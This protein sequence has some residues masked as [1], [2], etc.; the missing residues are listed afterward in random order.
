MIRHI[1]KMRSAALFSNLVLPIVYA[2]FVWFYT[3][4]FF[5]NQE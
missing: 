1:E 2:L 4:I 3:R 5:D